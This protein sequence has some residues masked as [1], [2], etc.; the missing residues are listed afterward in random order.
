MVMTYVKKV[1]ANRAQLAVSEATKQR[2][3]EAGIGS[4]N[5]RSL[6][7]LVDEFSVEDCGAFHLTAL[8]VNRR[9]NIGQLQQVQVKTF[10]NCGQCV[11]FQER[12][13]SQWGRERQA[14]NLRDKGGMNQQG[15][16]AVGRIRWRLQALL[17]KV[18]NPHSCTLG[19]HHEPGTRLDTWQVFGNSI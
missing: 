18:G 5:Q 11:Y 9:I 16:R 1:L 15:A 8:D 6:V 3:P 7:I 12:E 4:G 14:S 10:K 13:R 2:G 19:W 17:Q